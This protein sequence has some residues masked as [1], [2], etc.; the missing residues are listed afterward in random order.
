MSIILSARRVVEPTVEPL[1]IGETKLHLRVD[2]DYE[3]A[4]ISSLI[5]TAR[6]ECERV[7]WLSCCT[8]TWRVYLS[9][10]PVSP[11]LLPRHP[12]QS[13]SSIKYF[14]EADAEHTL[15]NSI[16][17]LTPAPGLDASVSLAADQDWPSEPL[18]TRQYPVV[19]EYVTG[20]GGSSS[21]PRA[22][23]QWM[24]LQI[25]AMFEQREAVQLVPGVSNAIKLDFI[26]GL[27]DEYRGFRFS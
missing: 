13:I 5:I 9:Q 18:S 15:S 22:I 14:D 27:L 17:A 12:V 10:W 19:I 2:D 23:K 4:L 21:V 1:L 16:Y 24:L 6:N 3:N 26:D 25:G 11:L 7:G 8:Q 20:F